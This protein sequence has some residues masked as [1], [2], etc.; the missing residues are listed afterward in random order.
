MNTEHKVST[1]LVDKLI[2]INFPFSWN[3]YEVTTMEMLDKLPDNI[4]LKLDK[5]LGWEYCYQLVINKRVQWYDV[6]YARNPDILC[7][8]ELTPLPDALAEMILRLTRYKLI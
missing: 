2:S 8:I 5:W 6:M 3:P 1:N 4:C 7:H